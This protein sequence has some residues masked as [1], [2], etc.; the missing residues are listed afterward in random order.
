[1]A[2]WQMDGPVRVNGIPYSVA[3]SWKVLA[4]GDFNGDRWM[5]ALWSDGNYMQLWEGDGLGSFLGSQL[6]RFP[7]GW[8][9]A[10]TGDFDGDGNHDLFWRNDAGTDAALWRMDG[11]HIVHQRGYSTSPAWKIEGGGDFNGDGR[12]DLV[13]TNGIQMQLWQTQPDLGFA[14]VGMPDFPRGWTLSAI[15][16]V[17]GDGN[18]DLL[19]FL[20]QLGE[21]AI[22][23]IH[24]TGEVRGRGYSV[25]PDWRIVQSGDFNADGYGDLIWSNGRQMQLWQSQG[26]YFQGLPM[27]EYPTAWS[28]I[29]Q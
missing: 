7:A 24:T 12:Q 26:S 13:W 27:D 22:W 5:D 19:W 18:A 4:T 20:P 10:A 17:S 15:T 16:D 14:G 25:G 11:A 9:L 8:R 2:L 23:E 1:M 21:L 6:P 28:I 3:S 29:R